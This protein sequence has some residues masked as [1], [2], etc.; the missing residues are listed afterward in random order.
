MNKDDHIL[1]AVGLGIGFSLL[2]HPPFT[3]PFFETTLKFV[4]PIT[5]GALFPDID[6]GYGRHRKTLHNLPILALFYWFPRYYGN[7]QY[8]WIGVLTHYLLDLL[9]SKRGLALFYPFTETEYSVPVGVSGT[10]QYTT[11]VTIVITL[12]ELG[13]TAG[14]L[15]TD[16]LSTYVL[17]IVRSMLPL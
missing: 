6:T 15:Y 9:G 3:T 8:V 11:L 13:I 16:T 12:A 10:S 7:L 2:L 1:N 4:L 17:P 5:L 14:I